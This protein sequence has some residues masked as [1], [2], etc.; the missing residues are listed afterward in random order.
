MARQFEFT[1][2]IQQAF[3][4]VFLKKLKFLQ[5]HSIRDRNFL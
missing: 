4:I 3:E 2:H 5:K 1:N